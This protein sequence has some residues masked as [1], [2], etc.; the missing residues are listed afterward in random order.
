MIFQKCYL[1]LI[2]F[3]CLL[4]CLHFPKNR[5]WWLL[6]YSLFISFFL[7]HDSIPSVFPWHFLSPSLSPGQAEPL[8]IDLRD[9]FTLVYDIKQREEMEKKAQKDKQCE[10]A[11]YQVGLCLV[12]KS[13]FF[14]SFSFSRCEA[15]SHITTQPTIHSHNGI[16]HTSSVLWSASPLILSV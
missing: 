9:L 1:F 12:F 5:S 11:V 7:L 15:R 2:F 13:V 16:L 3:S 14:F 10:Q 6:F 8:I 4:T